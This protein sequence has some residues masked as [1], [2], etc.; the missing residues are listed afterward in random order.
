VCCDIVC[1]C[2]DSGFNVFGP[3]A[4]SV[5]VQ[6]ACCGMFEHA[7]RQMYASVPTSQLS[8]AAAASRMASTSVR[9]PV[10]S[11]AASATT[12]SKSTCSVCVCVCAYMH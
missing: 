2:N 5:S 6:Y 12:S 10:L 8:Y 1:A 9:A 3:Q 4:T 11:S 7:Q